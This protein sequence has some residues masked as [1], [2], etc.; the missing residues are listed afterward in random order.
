MDRLNRHLHL[1]LDFLVQGLELVHV[2]LLGRPSDRETLGLVGLGDL[3]SVSTVQRRF[4]AGNMKN[5]GKIPCGSGPI[6]RQ[7]EQ[8]SEGGDG[9]LTWSTTWCAMRPLFCRMLKSPAPVA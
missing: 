2:S 1:R 4:T 6:E 7:Q 8:C 9:R 5:M 3:E